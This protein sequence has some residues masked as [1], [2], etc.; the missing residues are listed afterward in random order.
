MKLNQ[1]IRN[2]KSALDEISINRGKLYDPE[3]V[4]ACIA[5]F[6]EKGF[7]FEKEDV[8]KDEHKGKV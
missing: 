7:S 1:Y 8:L 4:D 3:A 5:L 2:I 6:K